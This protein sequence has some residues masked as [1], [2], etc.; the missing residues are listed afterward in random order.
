M[1]IIGSDEKKDTLIVLMN[2][3]EWDLLQ[4]ACGIPY[5]KRSRVAGT[6]INVNPVVGA[7]GALQDMKQFRKELGALQT[8]WDKLAT[9]I[10]DTLDK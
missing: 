6:A 5:D 2:N 4:R 1:Q 7:V 10:D 3:G 8:K 9:A